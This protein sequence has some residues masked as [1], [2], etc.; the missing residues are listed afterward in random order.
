MSD[1]KYSAPAVKKALDILELMASQDKSFTVTEISNL[2]DISTNSVFRILKEFEQKQYIVKDS[3]DSS[4]QLTARLY[5]LGNTIKS[6]ISLIEEAQDTMR[7]LQRHTKET[8]LLTRLDEDYRTLI[9]DQYESTHHIKFLSSVG[10]SYDSYTS[11]MGKCL[12]AFCSPQEISAYLRDTPLI[13]QTPNT[14][15]D[16]DCLLRELQ[17]IKQDRIAY[18]H[19]ESIIGLTCIACPIFSSHHHLEGAIGISGI[20]FRMTEEKL[21]SFSVLLSEQA[22]L[23]SK[24]FYFR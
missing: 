15:T 8:I 18:D 24:R 4:Y 5:Y 11:A 13:Q 19:Q 2:L 9:L 22:A 12:L 21:R 10:H 3:M 14:I 16:A 17:Q 7:F 20:S 23:L 1:Q 6:R